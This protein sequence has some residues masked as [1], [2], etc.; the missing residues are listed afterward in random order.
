MPNNSAAVSLSDSRS[1]QLPPHQPKPT[2]RDG[3][4]ESSLTVWESADGRIEVGVWEC[5]AGTFTAFRDGYDEVA[6]ILSG[7]ATVTGDDGTSV[8]IGP[9]STLIQPHGW[10]GTWTVHTAIRKSYVIHVTGT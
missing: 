8:E 4:T 1:V 9:G 10:R 3:Q 2:S 5:T 7:T 6:Q